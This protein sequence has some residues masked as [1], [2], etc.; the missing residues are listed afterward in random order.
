MLK[1]YT[2][3]NN[4]N[5]NSVVLCAESWCAGHIREETYFHTWIF[6]LLNTKKERKKTHTTGSITL[7]L[8]NIKTGGKIHSLTGLKYLITAAKI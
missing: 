6:A 3:D 4:N 1:L 8:N 7:H 2:S 5:N